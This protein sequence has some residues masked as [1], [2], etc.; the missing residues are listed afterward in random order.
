LK[1]LA[2]TNLDTVVGT[3]KFNKQHY[4]VQPL[5]G[6]QWRKDP[7]TGELVKE[8]VFNQIYKSVKITSKM[9]LYQQ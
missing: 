9:R 6:A 4:S 5:G 3:V 7:K 1:A 2:L 8:N